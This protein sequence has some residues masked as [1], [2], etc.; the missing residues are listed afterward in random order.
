[1]ELDINS[2]WVSSYTYSGT[3]PADIQG[4]KLLGSIQRPSD[5]YLHDGTRDFIAMFG[6]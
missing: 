2:E 6:R 5:R 1:M 4:H 3:T